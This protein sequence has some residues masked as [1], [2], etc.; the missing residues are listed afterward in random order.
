MAPLAR[1]NTNDVTKYTIAMSLRS[2][3]RNILTSTDPPAARPHGCHTNTHRS[4][5]KLRHI[6]S[7]ADQPTGSS[8]LLRPSP[9]QPAQAFAA[10]A[11]R[12]YG[13]HRRTATV[14]EAR[15]LTPPLLT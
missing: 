6:A 7:R 4:R 15:L 9:R 10:D 12:G 8:G 1:K 5:N 13:P 3:V 14:S 2:V 11:A